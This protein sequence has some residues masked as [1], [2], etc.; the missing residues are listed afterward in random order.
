MIRVGLA[1][2]R[3][4]YDGISAPWGPGKDYPEPSDSLGIALLR[5]PRT[6]S[7]PRCGAALFGLG[8]DA[9]RFG[10]PDWNP[11]GA[12][13]GPGKRI[14]LKPNLIRHWNP[15]S[16]GRGGSVASV[17]THG[18]ILR[19][20]ADYAFLAAGP[21]GTVAIAEAPRMDCDFEKIRSII[22]LDAIVDFY[23]DV[24]G[25]ELEVIDLR[26]EAVVFEDGIIVDRKRLPG[27]PAGYRAVD[28][29]DKSLP[30]RASIPTASAAPTTI[31]DRRRRS[32]AAAAT[33]ISSRRPSSP[34]TS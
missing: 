15:A 11:I 21:D 6:R 10:T 8:L 13:V 18:A 2:C 9:G 27:D 7:M 30:T 29:G 5:A 33:P 19:A 17:I 28:L 24:L 32:T 4:G 25:R 22:G 31:P 16:D 1:R 23:D 12:L 14:V 34:R 20:V 26:R 3:P